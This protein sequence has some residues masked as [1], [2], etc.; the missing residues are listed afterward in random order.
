MELL[1]YA[2]AINE[3][4]EVKPICESLGIVDRWLASF[5]GGEI[6]ERGMLISEF[7]SADDPDVALAE[8]AT[9]IS[10]KCLVFA[11]YGPGGRFE[12]QVPDNLIH[13]EGYR[14]EKE[15]Q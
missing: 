14:Y 9:S 4:V 1:D 6:S 10:G 12:H 13:T 15:T 3:R 7:G 5:V 2:E 11:A 8:Y